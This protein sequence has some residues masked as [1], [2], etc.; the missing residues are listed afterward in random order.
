M[1]IIICLNYLLLCNYSSS[2]RSGIWRWLSWVLQLWVSHKA[3]IKVSAETAAISWINGGR[4]HFQTQSSYRIG[5]IQFLKGCWTEGFGLSVRWPS[6]LCHMGLL[7]GQ[8]RRGQ[9]S[10][11]HQSEQVRGREG[12][13]ARGREQ[14]RQKSVFDNPVLDVQPFSFAV[15]DSLE[16]SLQAQPTRKQSGYTREHIQ[17]GRT[18]GA[19]LETAS[20]SWRKLFQDNTN[21]WELYR[22]GFVHFCKLRQIAKCPIEVNR[23][24][25]LNYYLCSYGDGVVH[26]ELPPKG[27]SGCYRGPLWYLC[28]KN[29]NICFC[30][31][32]KYNPTLCSLRYSLTYKTFKRIRHHLSS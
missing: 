26:R 11:L 27:K 4:I 7:E 9:L 24:F 21:L 28:F 5:K 17:G 19:I 29:N 18:I 8:L 12:V 15:F 13:P 25:C 6:V 23:S 22:M 16:I 32:S 30:L 1:N 2:G 3:A 31:F 10:S 20:P 14:T